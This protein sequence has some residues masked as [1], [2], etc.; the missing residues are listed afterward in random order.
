MEMEIN[1]TNLSTIGFKK[2]A[3]KKYPTYSIMSGGYKICLMFKD[4][5]WHLYYNDEKN[6]HS[7][8]VTHFTEIF[9]FIAEDFFLFGK[10]QMRIDIKDLLEGDD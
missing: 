9:G 5:I 8:S 3:G 2:E 7:H 10:R 4:K 6:K 1:E